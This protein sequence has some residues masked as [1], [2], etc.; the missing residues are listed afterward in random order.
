M[1]RQELIKSLDAEVQRCRHSI[2]VRKGA[3]DKFTQDIR[4]MYQGRLNLAIQLIDLL[5]TKPDPAD[6]RQWD[7]EQ[8]WS[9]W[10]I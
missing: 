7:S 2:D 8:P 4:L 6:Y 10:V 5:H 3:E 1:T 9:G